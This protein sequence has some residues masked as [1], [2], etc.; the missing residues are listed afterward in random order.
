MDR[1]G[2]TCLCRFGSALAAAALTASN[3]TTVATALATPAHASAT[4]A[5]PV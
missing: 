2:H 3:A 1:R 5:T 4:R